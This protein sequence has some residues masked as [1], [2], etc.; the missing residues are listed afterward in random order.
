MAKAR[1][2]NT[3]RRVQQYAV[4]LYRTLPA[5]LK[6]EVI[7]ALK[8]LGYRE[9]TAEDGGRAMRPSIHS[10]PGIERLSGTTWFG[11]LVIYIH[12]A[13]RELSDEG[14]LM[15]IHDLTTHLR[16]YECDVIRHPRKNGGEQS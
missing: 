14:R 5:D 8:E 4:R 13:M 1:K 12:G 9:L 7:D 2:S 16:R 15:L 6:Y 3:T 11:T 10:E